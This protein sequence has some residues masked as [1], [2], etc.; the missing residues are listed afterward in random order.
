M[1]KLPLDAKQSTYLLFYLDLSSQR[2]FRRSLGRSLGLTE[3]SETLN[4]LKLE[5]LTEL[6]VKSSIKHIE[7]TW[8]L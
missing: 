4:G 2:D 8:F 7:S 3:I 5:I 6:Q 1:E